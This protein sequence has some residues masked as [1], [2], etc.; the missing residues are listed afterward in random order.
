MP[1]YAYQ[2]KESGKETPKK[3]KKQQM[4]EQEM[5]NRTFHTQGRDSEDAEIND[6]NFEQDEEISKVTM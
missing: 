1:I 4:P 3:A 2:I 6:T 5:M